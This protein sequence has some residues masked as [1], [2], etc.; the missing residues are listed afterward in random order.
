[1]FK[2]ML[3]LSIFTFVL[4]AS[5]AP[6][7]H[8]E[9][10]AAKDSTLEQATTQE[11]NTLVTQLKEKLHSDMTEENVLAQF[12]EPDQ[13][14]ADDM[15]GLP[16]YRYDYKEDNSYSLQ[17]DYQLVDIEAL[18]DNRLEAII[19]FDFDDNQ[20]VRSAAVYYINAEEEV[21]EYRVFADGT[22]K[23][24]VIE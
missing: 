15:Y 12:G 21:V 23:N 14:L 11:A 17:A 9:S 19:Y 13:K 10:V 7:T 20:N 6:V 5:S 8:G 1:M 22:E 3:S 4:F 16:S 24:M 2:F 18:K